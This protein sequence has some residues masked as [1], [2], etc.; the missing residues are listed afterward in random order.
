MSY[1]INNMTEKLWQSLPGG[2]PGP[3]GPPGPSG[4]MNH[5]SGPSGPKIHSQPASTTIATTSSGKR[6]V[7]PDCRLSRSRI[8]T[9]DGREAVAILNLDATQNKDQQLLQFVVWAQDSM[10]WLL[11]HDIGK[12]VSKLW[13]KRLSLHVKFSH[14]SI[15]QSHS[16]WQSITNS[17][18]VQ[19]IPNMTLWHNHHP[20]WSHCLHHSNCQWSQS[21]SSSSSSNHWIW[22]Y[23]IHVLKYDIILLLYI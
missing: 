17:S 13:L 5:C 16:D 7:G 18:S 21:T 14:Q 10:S 19:F 2:P 8:C 3:P 12:L 6:G 1:V 22:F 20:H 4:P 11:S 15:N 9:L 23:Q